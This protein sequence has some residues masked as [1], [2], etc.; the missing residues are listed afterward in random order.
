[1]CKSSFSPT[2]K[3]SYP[4]KHGGANHDADGNK[5]H[6]QRL[7]QANANGTYE[8]REEQQDRYLGKYVGEQSHQVVSLMA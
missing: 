4:A 7:A 2:T 3:R 6:N 1:M 5:R 8:R